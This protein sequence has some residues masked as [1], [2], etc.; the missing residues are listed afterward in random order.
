MVKRTATIAVFLV[1]LSLAAFAD[2][3][4]I[5]LANVGNNI[6]GGVYVVPY[7][8][9]VQS[10]SGSTNYTVACDSYFNEVYVG[11]TWTGT[12]NTW[13]TLG[14]A[15]FGNASNAPQL[16]TEAAWLYNQYLTNQPLATP[17]A[18]NF[19]IWSL[20]Q[21][22]YPDPLNTATIPGY[23]LAAQNLLAAANQWYTNPADASQLS[24]YQSSLLIF[25]PATDASG[26]NAQEY[27]TLTSVPEPGN[28]LV[29]GA[30][31][32]VGCRFLKR[33]LSIC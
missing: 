9:N 24:W 27:I 7:Y 4:T 20:F 3:V 11:E 13:A 18:T 8:L 6:A 12:E 33:K 14:Q 17:A 5:T 19:A 31:L 30:G 2:P 23:D 26:K 32:L 28:V 21:S 29:F 15:K 25:T 10:S 16:Y 1:A 22:A